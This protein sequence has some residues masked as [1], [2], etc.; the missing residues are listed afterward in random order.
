MRD[1]SLYL[2]EII[3][4]IN[5]IYDYTKN[6]TRSD[7]E[8]DS[9]TSKAVIR[10]FEIIGEAVKHLPQEIKNKSSYKNWKQIA[11]MRDKL[12]HEYFGVDYS[13]VWATIETDLP[14]LKNAVIKLLEKVK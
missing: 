4:Q 8:D 6:M 1:H 7:F 11:G 14:D 9:K 10:S 13:I 5:D 2:Y 3:E 12:I